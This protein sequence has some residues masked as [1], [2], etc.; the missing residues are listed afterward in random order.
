MVDVLNYLRVQNIEHYVPFFFM[1]MVMFS[2]G[3]IS[4]SLSSISFD[5][6]ENCFQKMVNVY[7][8]YKPRKSKVS[9]KLAEILKARHQVNLSKTKTILQS[10]TWLIPEVVLTSAKTLIILSAMGVIGLIV[11]IVWLNNVGAAIILCFLLILLPGKYFSRA[12]IRKQERYAEQLSPA[13]RTFM[14]TLE[15]KGNVRMALA[16]IVNKQPE[17]TKSLFQKVLWRLDSGIQPSEALKIITREIN[18]SHAKLFV[19]LVLEAY[20]HGDSLIPQFS[21]LAGQVDTMHR[22]MIKNNELTS[23]GRWQNM[24]IHLILLGLALM[25]L[26]LLPESEKYLT[27]EPIGRLIVLLSFVSVLVGVIF[28]RIMSRV[29]A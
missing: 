18:L 10:V 19:Q 9:P 1:G 25:L 6:L 5:Y 2:V 3:L 14:V 13:I 8:K 15:K 4:Y 12:D 17:P 11:G 22:L 27:Q 23:P 29:D 16:E 28:D 7:R 20:N 24:I 21:R 26:R